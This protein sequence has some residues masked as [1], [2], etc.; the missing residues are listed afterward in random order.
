MKMPLPMILYESMMMSLTMTLIV[1]NVISG[2]VCLNV[3]W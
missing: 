1:M 3:P 2:D